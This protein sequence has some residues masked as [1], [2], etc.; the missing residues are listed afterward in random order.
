VGGVFAPDRCKDACT[1]RVLRL[2]VVALL[3][4]QQQHIKWQKDP[5]LCDEGVRPPPSLSFVL[6]HLCCP[7]LAV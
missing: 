2:F 3:A 4:S 7:L 6:T 5:W 1:A